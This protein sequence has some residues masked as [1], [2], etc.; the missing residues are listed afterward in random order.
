M[1]VQLRY[2]SHSLPRER[3]DNDENCLPQE[4]ADLAEQGTLEARVI[5]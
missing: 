5:L 4:Q 3:T 1:K 2:V